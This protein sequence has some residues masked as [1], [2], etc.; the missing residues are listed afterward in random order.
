MDE[1]GEIIEGIV[2][3]VVVEGGAGDGLG[4]SRQEE[5]GK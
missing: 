2:V 1:I 5:G 3:N 4:G